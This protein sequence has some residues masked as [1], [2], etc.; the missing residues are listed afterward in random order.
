MGW[1]HDTLR[2]MSNDPIHRRYHHHDMTFGLLYAFSEN[3][4]LPL[5]HDEVVHGKGA[6]LSKMPGDRWQCFANLRAYFGFMWAHPGKKLLFMGGEFAQDREWNHDLSLDWHLLD[7]PDHRG[8]QMLV[9]DLNALYRATPALYERDCE[10]SGFR[11]IVGDDQNNSVFAFARFGDVPESVAVAVSNFTPVARENYKIGVPLPGFY[12]EAVN[13]DAAHY[14]GSNM[15]NL[16][17]LQAQAEPSHGED[18]SIS[19]TLPPLATL[20]L[21]REP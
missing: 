2:F 9:R 20:I 14:G 6:L 13:T 10:A 15:G 21:V 1:M 17:G 5:S 12:R 7:E 3:F 4:I 19:L 11:W 8:V 16:G 18:F